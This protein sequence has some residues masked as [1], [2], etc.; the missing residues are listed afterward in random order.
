M[1]LDGLLLGFCL[2]FCYYLRSSELI[3][4]EPL[5]GTIPPF[6]DFYWMLVLIVPITPLLLDL[7]GYYD[8]PLARRPEEQITKMGR[9]GFWLALLMGMGAIFGR[10]EMPSRTVLMLFFVLA[11]IFL[12]LR[13]L[14]T[15][16]FLVRNYKKGLLGERTVV[17]GSRSD[18]ELF[19]NGLTTDE[20][21]ELQVTQRIDLDQADPQSI[22]RIVHQHAAGRVV[23]VSPQSPLNGDLPSFF[24]SEGI[25]VCIIADNISG[26]ATLPAIRRIGNTRTL[27][28]RR[29][30][31][32]LWHSA[33]KRLID[34]LGATLGLLLLSPLWLAIAIAINKTSPGPVIFRQVRSGKHGR[35]FT[36]LKFRT[37][38][39]NAPSLHAALAHQNEMQGP[40]FKITCDPR[41]TP[42]GAFLRRTS[43]DEIP[44]LLNVLRGEMSI[45]GPR[46]LPDYETEQIEKSTH[47]RRLSVKPG[48]T[49]LW[50][51]KGR[52]S[53]QSFD[54]WVKLDLEYIDRASL[55]LDITIILATIPAVL[56]RRGA[57]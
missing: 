12:I 5:R 10:L 27:V 1:I 19:V 31:Q 16:T 48:L 30:K 33:V 28:F 34:I 57:R 13:A 29:V 2:W 55:L 14:L 37:M 11:P 54:D 46:P 53:I 18:A 56:L 42:L 8:K 32:G 22:K 9:A 51:I 38:V 45:V 6:S 35:R 44:Q 23:F 4:F 50:Q 24:E 36:I 40:V 3:H 15:R 7:H 49:C 21:L 41:V 26:I 25:E 52:N 20:R 43:L 17:I 47:R 39:P